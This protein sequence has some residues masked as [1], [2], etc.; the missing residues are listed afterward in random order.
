MDRNDGIAFFH[1]PVKQQS[2][3]AFERGVLN[4]RVERLLAGKVSVTQ[5]MPRNIVREQCEDGTVVADAEPVK[6]ALYYLLAATHGRGRHGRSPCLAIKP[7]SA[8]IP[9]S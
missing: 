5:D 4:L 2:G 1:E 3:T 6:V 9:I 8:A 7:G